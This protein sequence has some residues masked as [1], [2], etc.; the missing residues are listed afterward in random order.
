MS[1]YWDAGVE[2]ES[3]EDGKTHKTG[4]RSPAWIYPQSTHNTDARAGQCIGSTASHEVQPWFQNVPIR[5]GM[6]REVDLSRNRQGKTAAHK[7][8]FLLTK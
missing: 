1:K 2:Q 5:L 6:A 3:I 8:L 7:S 4:S